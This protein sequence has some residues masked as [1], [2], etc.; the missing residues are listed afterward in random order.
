MGTS[1]S[2][3]HARLAFRS[4]IHGLLQPSTDGSQANLHGCL[5]RRVVFFQKKITACQPDLSLGET[6]HELL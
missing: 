6:C 4:A 5:S 2:K 1:I 3:H